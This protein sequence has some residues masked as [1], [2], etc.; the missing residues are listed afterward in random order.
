MKCQ[1]VFGLYESQEQAEKEILQKEQP[2]NEPV[3]KTSEEVSAEAEKQ[4]TSAEGLY[5]STIECEETTKELVAAPGDDLLAPPQGSVGTA[6]SFIQGEPYKENRPKTSAFGVLPKSLR[7]TMPADFSSR[8][9]VIAHPFVLTRFEVM[10]RDWRKYAEGLVQSGQKITIVNGDDNGNTEISAV[11][12]I[13]I[14]SCYRP[15][16]TEDNWSY[17]WILDDRQHKKRL[18]QGADENKEQFSNLKS[19]GK[20][21][22]DLSRSELSRRYKRRFKN[23][24]PSTLADKEYLF[25]GYLIDRYGSK[26]R[27]RRFLAFVSVHNSGLAFDIRSN[28]I[29]S[30]KATI[31][32]QKNTTLFLWLRDNAHKYGFTPYKREPWH[33]ELLPPRRSYF[34]GID[35]VQDGNYNVRT[36]ERGA[37]TDLLTSRRDEVQNLF[38]DDVKQPLEYSFIKE[39]KETKQG[40]S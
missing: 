17:R 33:W 23:T 24:K 10:N 30:T 11:E 14:S 19:D 6:T 5:D 18:Q 36:V 16:P 34:T 26:E 1:V 25:D 9:G 12:N 7:A 15:G 3:Q 22:I 28:G 13:K 38:E 21:V 31:E 39:Y 2:V 37:L 8:A 40:V 35:F 27:G 32:Y 29:K 4:R 20:G